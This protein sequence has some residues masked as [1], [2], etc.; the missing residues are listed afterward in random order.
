[1]Q[2]LHARKKEQK[3]VRGGCGQQGFAPMVGALNP[4]MYLYKA[5]QINDSFTSPGDLIVYAH[6][7]P[8][9]YQ[10]GCGATVWAQVGS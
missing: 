7:G 8:Y 10:V 2:S 5:R 3:T 9:S 4:A 1:V 6:S